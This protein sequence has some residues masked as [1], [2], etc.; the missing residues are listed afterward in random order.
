[1]LRNIILWYILFLI[2]TA[3]WIAVLVFCINSAVNASEYVSR[4]YH[5]NGIF[6]VLGG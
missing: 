2:V 1:M 5:L 3:L 6:E 4:F